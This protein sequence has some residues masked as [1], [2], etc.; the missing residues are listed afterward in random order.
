MNKIRE[1]DRLI[2][3]KL[4]EIT[5]LRSVMDG[6][7]SPSLG[8]KVQ[9]SATSDRLT[10][11]IARIIELEDAINNDIDELIALKIKAKNIIEKIDDD[12]LK[13]IL[14]KRY[15]Q[16]K[17]FEQISVECNYGWRHTHRLHSKALQELSKVVIE[18]H[19][20]IVI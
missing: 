6:V 20:E 7:G 2:D 16:N 13:V 18:S 4:E 5:R 12:I 19:I 9:T 8:D 10:N 1:V 3:C 17:T 15:F 11:V 14:Y